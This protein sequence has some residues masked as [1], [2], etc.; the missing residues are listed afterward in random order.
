MMMKNSTCL[1]VALC[2]CLASPAGAV[3]VS[4]YSFDDLN[5]GAGLTGPALT[6]MGA[7]HTAGVAGGIVG[8]AVEF[9]GTTGNV[10]N[11]ALGFGGGG[12][13]ELGN[14]FTAS[15]W[16]NLDTD[17]T[18]DTTRFFVYEG[19][20]D[21]DIS[22]GLRASLGGEPGNNDGQTFTNG[23]GSVNYVD[24]YTPGTWQHVLMTYDSDGTTTTL[25]TY[26]DG[27]LS[28]TLSGPTANLTTDSINIGNARG[29]AL[30]RAFDGKIDEIAIW[31]EVLTHGQIAKVVG[32]GLQG[33]TIPDVIPEPVPGDADGNGTVNE[34]D[35]FLISD[36]LSDS[37]IIGTDGDLDFDSQVT[38]GDFR[39]WK[40]VASPAALAAAGFAVP[41]PSTALLL[42]GALALLGVRAVRR[43]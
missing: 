21:Y 9:T 7:G 19:A 34:F 38:V 37:V 26:I 1:A 33:Q 14:N 42:A 8:N 16:Y 28:G 17:A 11:T 25:N 43:R 15:A 6:E 2:V 35:F 10:L 39:L 31:D 41:E 32:F 20:T 40:N 23:I 27:I 24:V 29:S 22:Y 12:G 13:D 18:S 30:N 4:R 36:N 3:L 5:N